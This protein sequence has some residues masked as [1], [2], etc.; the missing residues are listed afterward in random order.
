M[1][2]GRE[3]KLIFHREKVNRNRISNAH[4]MSMPMPLPA[5]SSDMQF[6]IRPSW[7]CIAILRVISRSVFLLLA[8][9]TFSFFCDKSKSNRPAESDH[10]A[11][12]TVLSS[13]V[14][15][16]SHTLSMVFQDMMSEGL[17][18]TGDRALCLG[19]GKLSKK[20]TLRINGLNVVYEKDTQQDIFANNNLFDF[21][22]SAVKSSHPYFPIAEVDQ[23][24][25]IGGVFAVH[26]SLD[27]AALN[28]NSLLELMPNFRTVYL[29]RFDV[30]GLDTVIAFR[31]VYQAP[32]LI[33]MI[34][35]MANECPMSEK[36]RAS[37]KNLEHILLEPPRAS[38]I[39]SNENLHSNI[40]Y[41]PNI[42]GYPLDS[43]G[44]AYIDVGANSYKSSIGSWFQSHYPMHNHK[45]DLFAIEADGSF[46]TE[47]ADQVQVKVL[48]FGDWVKNE[49]GVQNEQKREGLGLAD[50]LTKTVTA[51]DYVVMTM[52]VDGAEFQLVPYLLRSGALCL[53]DE[54][55]L[56]CHYQTPYKKKQKHRRS[57]WECLSLYGLLR[58]KGVAVHQWW[59]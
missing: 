32:N 1:N 55:F 41:L 34:P 37:I 4:I 3:E 35:E 29:R 19:I 38:W 45:F 58:E 28:L 7:G 13:E 17:L 26:L 15:W 46:E 40:Q 8:L 10:A 25:K 36:K 23:T 42:L 47:Y 52:D 12:N 9:A 11:V 22:L 48:P 31:K 39:E 49:S 54:L 56:E 59:G 5:A 51:D 18:K 53:V 24:L 27:A 2:L 44:Y 21:E 43:T 50:W 16:S 14:Q 33:E 6:V 57:Y 20:E 30:F